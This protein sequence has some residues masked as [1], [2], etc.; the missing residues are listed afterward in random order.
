MSS[1]NTDTMSGLG[2]PT[3]W[4]RREGG[5]EDTAAA[6]LA[7]ERRGVLEWAQDCIDELIGLA[8]A[9]ERFALWRTALESG[10]PRVEH[11]GLPTSCAQNHL[12][13]LGAPGTAKKTFARIIGEVLFGWG[14]ITRPHVTEVT[15]N[16]ITAGD[17]SHS[18][19]RMKNVCGGA[20]GGVLFI[21]EAHRL[22]PNTDNG[23]WGIE[24]IYALLT[25]MAAY[26]DDLVV[27]LAGHPR[28]MQD[29]LTTHAGLAARFPTTI[30]FASYTPDDVVA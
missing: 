6:V 24:A 3:G 21:D 14:T 29:F 17:P 12:V 5:E 16:D 11:G 28:P 25:S 9:K 10:H 20:R 13:F 30:T 26:R 7:G 8:E 27:I 4:C 23:P 22:A 1:S 19:T 2:L 18:A 15:A